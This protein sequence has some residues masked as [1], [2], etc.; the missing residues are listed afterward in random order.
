MSNAWPTGLPQRL[1]VDQATQGVGDGLVEYAPDTGP[2][3]T[4]LGT[5]AAMAPLSGSVI[6]TGAQIAIFRDFFKTT[7][8]AGSL[9]FTFPDPVTGSAL[10]VKFTKSGGMPTWAPL[11]GDNWQLNLALF[12]L[13]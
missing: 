6:C 2:S 12:V 11:G 8:L 7:I 3:L 5:S 10:L 1:Q 4:R 13:P 9:P